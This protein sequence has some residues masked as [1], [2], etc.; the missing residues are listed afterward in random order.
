MSAQIYNKT[1]SIFNDSYFSLLKY[2]FNYFQEKRAGIF[3]NNQI[4]LAI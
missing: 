4:E 1:D 3:T 2:V